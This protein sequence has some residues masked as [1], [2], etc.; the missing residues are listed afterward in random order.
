MI[1]NSIAGSI[2]VKSHAIHKTWN[3]S[4][5][6]DPRKMSNSAHVERP[7]SKISQRGKVAKIQFLSARNPARNCFRAGI[8]VKTLVT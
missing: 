6:L 4:V 2:F 7:S 3:L 8:L 1:G 5:V